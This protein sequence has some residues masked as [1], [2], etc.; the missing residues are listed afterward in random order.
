MPEKETDGMRKGSRNTESSGNTESSRNTGGSMDREEITSIR[1]AEAYREY[2]KGFGS[3]PGL[4]SIERLLAE[5]DNPQKGPDYVHIAGT[6]GKGSVLA[7]VSTALQKAGYRVGRYFSPAVFSPREVIQVNGRPISQRAF[8]EGMECLRRASLSLVE[9]GHKQPTV[10]EVETALAFW[11]FRK[12]QCR[13]VVLEC[14]FGGAYD[15]TNVIGAPKVAVITPVSLDHV[16]IL[17][18]TLAEIAE[19]KAG[20]IKR[21][22]IAVSASQPA[23]VQDALERRCIEEDCPLHIVDEG[24]LKKRKSSLRRQSFVA[25]GYGELAIRLAGRWQIENALLAVQA[26]AALQEQGFS[27]SENHIREGLW[28]TAWP[29]RFSLI[30]QKPLFLMDGAHNPQGAQALCDSLTFYF[31]NRR[32]LYIMGMLKDKDYESVAEK[33]APLAEHIITVTPPHNPRA[34]SAYE[35]ARTV[36]AYNPRVTSADSLQEAVELSLLLADKDAVIVA[37]GSLSFLGELQSIVQ[38][39]DKI[40][41]DTHGQ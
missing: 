23:P 34:L 14:G 37:F 18:N 35:L 6:N 26:L 38:E 13:I 2:L 24:M 22:C 33:T 3:V 29:G 9:A 20:I 4:A 41:R 7:F 8:V 11:Y 17:G 25:E 32:I 28:E 19:Q 5:L 1:Q 12:K 15:A 39:K 27:I 30:S 31:T 21:G 16:G 10:F 40:R 36:Q